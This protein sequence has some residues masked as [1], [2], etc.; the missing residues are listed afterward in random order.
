MQRQNLLGR[1]LIRLINVK[2]IEKGVQVINIG[3][4]SVDVVKTAPTEN[5]KDHAAVGDGRRAH[6]KQEETSWVVFEKSP[7]GN[8]SRAGRSIRENRVVMERVSE[9]RIIWW[10]GSDGFPL[11]TR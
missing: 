10:V 4:F 7:S 2:G 1:I 8:H 9:V 3:L 11:L 5:R 6:R